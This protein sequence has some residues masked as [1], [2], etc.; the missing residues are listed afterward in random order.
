MYRL[1]LEIVSFAGGVAGQA[2]ELALGV[3]EAFL[4]EGGDGFQIL[5]HRVNFG[6]AARFHFAQGGEGGLLVLSAI[7][8]DRA[9]DEFKGFALSLGDGGDGLNFLAQFLNF[10]AVGRMR[11]NSGANGDAERE[12][13]CGGGGPADPCLAR[14]VA[15][16]GF[17]ECPLIERGHRAAPVP[18]LAAAG[19]AGIEMAG[20]A[21]FFGG[22]D[23]FVKERHPF[24]ASGMS[25]MSGM[26]HR[27]KL[28]RFLARAIGVGTGRGEGI[29][30]ARAA[31]VKICWS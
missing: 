11:S 1:G 10:G 23:V 12:K 6:L 9:R 21:V 27:T 17:G 24:F 30:S 22:V 8:G 15:A 29:A 20:E 2:H 7:F 14:A 25:G 26:V 18:D 28:S 4:R 3:V 16:S 31:R 5:A 19:V 13:Y